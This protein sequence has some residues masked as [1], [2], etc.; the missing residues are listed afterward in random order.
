MKKSYGRSGFIW[1][2]T[3]VSLMIIALG[4]ILLVEGLKWQI[5][6]NID[7]VSSLKA[8]GIV[9]EL[10]NSTIREVFPSEEDEKELIIVKTGE[11]GKIQMVQANTPLINKMVAAFAESLQK[12]YSKMDACQVDISYG[13]LLGSKVLSQSGLGFDIKV[14]PLSVTKYDFETE[15]ESQ[16]IN[17]TKYKVY[18]TLESE[19]RILQPFS[20]KD[21]KIENKVLISEAVI[22]GEVPDS[23]VNV[24]KEDILDVT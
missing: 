21:I 7:A 18:I 8:K 9:T 12:K 2:K 14:L 24:P 20:D 4:C 23:Y 17:Q 5:G 19:V 10:I 15:F 1:K 11:D 6:P 16:G 13:T 22:L 3:I